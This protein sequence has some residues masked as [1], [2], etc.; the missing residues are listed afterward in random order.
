M[1]K[2]L[3]LLLALIGFSQS[4]A[5]RVL[6]TDGPVLGGSRIIQV[7]SE[8]GIVAPR[9][10]FQGSNCDALAVLDGITY[11]I[12]DCR[13]ISTATLCSVNMLTG[14][15]HDLARVG[16]ACFG[17]AAFNGTV[18]VLGYYTGGVSAY[19]VRSGLLTP[20]G[21]C[22]VGLRYI[23]LTTSS[24]GTLYLLTLDS[25]ADGVFRLGVDLATGRVNPLFLGWVRDGDAYV[26][27]R[28]IACSA[29][30][31]LYIVR[32]DGAGRGKLQSIVSDGFGNMNVAATVPFKGQGIF[33]G[34]VFL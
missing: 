3:T 18:Y 16:D 17:L 19:D 29:T 22:G 15:L 26:R 23:G 28:G 34:P 6:C 25:F 33:Q 11:T 27:P 24:D 31:T 2:T 1:K 13:Y 14:E 7:D 10:T 30:G 20:L 5:Y 8:T 9:C 12:R 21:P 32:D 4:Y